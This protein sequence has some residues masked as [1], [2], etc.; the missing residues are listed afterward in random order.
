[1]Q[2]T[3]VLHVS[4]LGNTAENLPGTTFPRALCLNLMPRRCCQISFSTRIAVCACLFC[5]SRLFILRSSVMSHSIILQLV[6]LPKVCGNGIYIYSYLTI[7]FERCFA[8]R[9]QAVV[10]K[11]CVHAFKSSNS[12][13]LSILSWYCLVL[14]SVHRENAVVVQ[15]MS[16]CMKAYVLFYRLY[17]FRY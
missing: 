2:G 10:A 6:S 3:E 16:R 14:I 17:F 12:S 11:N 5:I 1:M 13:F 9:F 4:P 15:G 7:A 8:S